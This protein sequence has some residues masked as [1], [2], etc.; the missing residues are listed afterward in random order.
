MEPKIPEGEDVEPEELMKREIAKDP[1]EPRLKPI[2]NDA[3]AI[4][5]LPAWI[6]KSY[7]TND[8]FFD[9]KTG[10]AS[11]NFG[12]VVVKSQW[13]PGSYS[14]Y[15]GDRV[16]QIYCGDGQKRDGLTYYPV[17]PPVMIDDRQ[18]MATCEEPNPTQEYLDKKKRLD[19]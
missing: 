3:P 17:E 4:G 8:Q 13:W 12:V 15:Q 18:E 5:G 14:F 19:A 2:T 16:Y 7:N 1:W 10:K 9:E 6:V 11:Q